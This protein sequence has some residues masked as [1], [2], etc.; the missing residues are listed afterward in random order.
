ME[1][2]QHQ[3]EK[4]KVKRKVESKT[5]LDAYCIPLQFVQTNVQKVEQTYCGP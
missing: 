4:K 1:I 3:F 5:I 2:I